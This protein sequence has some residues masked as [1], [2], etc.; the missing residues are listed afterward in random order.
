M[1]NYTTFSR[2]PA[3]RPPTRKSEKV[4]KQEVEVEGGGGE[5]MLRHHVFSHG[6]HGLHG[7]GQPWWSLVGRDVDVR[8]YHSR[9]H[10]PRLR[11]SFISRSQPTDESIPANKTEYRS[12]SKPQMIDRLLFHAPRIIAPSFLFIHPE[13][14]DVKAGR[15]TRRRASSASPRAIASSRTP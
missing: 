11:I 13:V 1:V 14:G 9:T 7:L 8:T 4:E 15:G 10:P 2:P 12:S 3:G 5:R 6:F